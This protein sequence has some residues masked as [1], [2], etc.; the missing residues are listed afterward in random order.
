VNEPGD[1]D[2]RL[3]VLIRQ[4]RRLT[5]LLVVVGIALIAHVAFEAFARRTVQAER[6]VVRDETGAVRAELGPFQM[7]AGEVDGVPVPSSTTCLQLYSSSKK[8]FVYQC[9]PW[10]I[11]V[12]PYLMMGEET[13]GRAQVSV[14]PYEGFARLRATSPKPG[15]PP[16]EFSV[17]TFTDGVVVRLSDSKGRTRELSPEQP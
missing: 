6:F 12:G 13:G 9:V 14:G 4:Q 10:D 17:G 8:A 1:R 16:N 15:L 2:H 5:I 7:L 3:E 11:A